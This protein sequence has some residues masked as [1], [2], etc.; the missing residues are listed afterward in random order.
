MLDE[1]ADYLASKWN[2]RLKP[3]SREFMPV[4][5]SCCDFVA[6]AWNR[7]ECMRVLGHTLQCNGSVEDCFANSLRCAW[8]AFW[9]NIGRPI[10]KQFSVSLKMKR[11]QFVVLPILAFRFTRW[12]FTLARGRR[13]DA[14]QRK[15]VSIILNCKMIAGETPAQFVKRRQRLVSELIGFR[16]WSKL[17]AKRVVS[18]QDHLNRNTSNACWAAGLLVYRSPDDLAARR[19][20]SCTGR[21]HTRAVSGYCSARWCE[22]VVLAKQHVGSM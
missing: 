7:V 14:C 15:M 10:F 21:P 5:G 18:W 9:K 20:D 12:P 17:W 8:A 2:L 19:R 4:F 11:L 1:A 3:S 16:T 13:L 6:G 22:S